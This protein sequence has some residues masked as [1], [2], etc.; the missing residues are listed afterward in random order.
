[1]KEALR[2]YPVRLTFERAMLHHLDT[3]PGDYAGALQALPPRLLSMFVSAFQ[4]FLFNT[5]LSRRCC[6]GIPLD[7]PVPGDRLL[8]ADGKQDRV[9]AG[10]VGAAALQVSRRRAQVGLFVP[11][12]GGPLPAGEDPSGQLLGELGITGE[13]F[14]RASRLVGAAYE[15]MTRPVALSPEISPR[16]EGND[17]L[18]GFFLGPGRYATTVC[19]EFMKAD[20]AQMV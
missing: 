16:I 18:L 7:R 5:L 13:D 11:G 8:F 1:V 4:S 3:R 12:T 15:G 14:A 9:T 19:R 10:N 2:R 20:P 17:V 6:Q